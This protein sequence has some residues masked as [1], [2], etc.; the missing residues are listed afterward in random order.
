MYKEYDVVY[1]KRN[2]SE[3]VKKGTKG[4]IVLILDEK[5][6]EYEVEFINDIGEFLE[7]LSVDESDLDLK[8]G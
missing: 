8:K 6:S 1:A 7:L 4:A 5:C 3:M 2:L